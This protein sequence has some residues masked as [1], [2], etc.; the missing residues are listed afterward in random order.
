MRTLSRMVVVLPLLFLPMAAQA[1]GMTMT[2]SQTTVATTETQDLTLVITG[3]SSRKVALQVCDRNGQN[4][5]GGGNSTLGTIVK[6][7]PD[8]NNNV[9]VQYTAPAALPSTAVC[10]T[11]DTGCR[12]KLKATLK[13]RKGGVLRKKVSTATVT[14]TA[15]GVTSS[16]TSGGDGDSRGPARSADGRFVAFAS[17]ASNLPVPGGDT[18]IFQDVFLFDTCIGATGCTPGMKI[19]SVASDGSPANGPSSQPAIS[20]DG[21]W[22]AFV[23]SATN[24]VLNDAN[25]VAD[26][27]MRDTCLGEEFCTASTFRVSEGSDPDGAS[28]AP[29]VSGN[30]RY[31]V[32]RSAAT[33]LLGL[34]G[35][36]NGAP[37][38]FLRDTC[39]G[40]DPLDC[41]PSTVRV[42]V[43]NDGSEAVGTSDHPSVSADGRFVAFGS[44]AANLIGVGGDTNLA[45]DVFRRDT[46]TGVTGCAPSTARVSVANDSSEASGGD[47]LEPVIS[48]SGRYVVFRSAATNLI[49]VGNDN[50]V[51]A[52]IFLRDTCLGA[53]GGCTPATTRVSVANDG[54]EA[55]GGD[56]LEPVVSRDGRFVAFRS[57]ATNLVSGDGNS[58]PDIFVRDTCGGEPGCTPS[59]RRISVT[60]SGGEAAA[61]SF[62]PSLSGDGRFAAFPSDAD[63]I[64][65]GTG[66]VTNIYLART[67]AVVVPLAW[68]TNFGDNTAKVIDTE[69]NTVIATIPVGS[70]P[71]GIAL[72]PDGT[73]AY[74]TNFNDDS[75]SVIDAVSRTVINTISLVPTGGDGPRGVT[76]TSDGQRV[77]VSNN[78][79]DKVSAILTSSN[80]VFDVIDLPAGACPRGIIIPPGQTGNEEGAGT[81][82]FCLD[83]VTAFQTVPGDF[84]FHVIT[85]TFSVGDGPTSGAGRFDIIERVWVTNENSGTVS[86]VRTDVQP[87]VVIATINVGAAPSGI[88]INQDATRLYVAV[89]GLDRVTVINTA[90]NSII[91]NVTVG[92]AP[93][94]IAITPDG[95]RVYVANSGSNTV[96]VIDTATNAVVATIAVGTN[97]CCE[98]GVAIQ[99]GRSN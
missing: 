31:V 36:L 18:N 12:L 25:G 6:I 32:F 4:C 37:D 15:P 62:E 91:K 24:L 82:N 42:S 86:V 40:F 74:V 1:V 54:S 69:T 16:P 38:I 98:Q 43:A 2:P 27:Y 87:N 20:A 30:G 23:S 77:Y 3:T 63:L 70:G 88:A 97:P 78:L 75:V 39:A 29:G 67:G 85:D 47:T 26:V 49:G 95:S 76:I 96:S 10:Q 51:A 34:A 72:T 59:T 71:M 81:G 9:L 61:E 68:V 46:C 89:S 35:D 48:G 8:A 41:T 92:D 19:V 55:S 60:S 83:N 84:D 64:S 5:V 99:F 80:A 14:L 13:F 66:T 44:L 53:G 33:N 17:A 79:S 7:G 58:V 21:R 94:G 57:A 52:D 93:K 65:G 90:N 45:R 56:T 28:D 50:N 22:V 73:R 11:V